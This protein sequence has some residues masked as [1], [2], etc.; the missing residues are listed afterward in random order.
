LIQPPSPIGFSWK[1]V[2]RCF[3]RTS[4]PKRP[5]RLHRGQR[6]L[7]LALAVKGNERADVDIGD[8]VA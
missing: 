6:G 7:H 2:M 3:S 4:A 5:R 1:R 8:A